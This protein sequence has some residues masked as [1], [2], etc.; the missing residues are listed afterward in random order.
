MIR[1]G[2][3]SGMVG[4]VVSLVVAF[5]H[6]AESVSGEDFTTDHMH[7]MAE[8]APWLA[9]HFGN[10][11]AAFLAVFALA[12]FTEMMRGSTG[13]AWARLAR[14]TAVAA[15]GLILVTSAV[16]GFAIRR[17]A[18]DFVSA[19]PDP[20]SAHYLATQGFEHFQLSMFSMV[21]FAYFGVTQ[22]LYGLATWN[23]GT[24]PKWLGAI[25]IGFG[26]VGSVVGA[27][28]LLFGISTASITVFVVT[29]NFFILWIMVMSVITWRSSRDEAPIP[30]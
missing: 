7:E 24:Y 26:I 29:W 6:P 2:A 11:A 21:I 5:L 28:Q 4:G 20:G 17:V 16:D 8:S 1:I 14:L 25:A 10:T 22:L 9:G 27:V 13:Q 12:A 19:N 23:S 15:F 30:G 3:L 18:E